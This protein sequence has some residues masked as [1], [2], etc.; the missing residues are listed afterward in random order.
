V[1]GHAVST[2][3]WRDI[4]EWI[5]LLLVLVGMFTLARLAW[6]I[7]TVVTSWVGGTVRSRRR[8]SD[9]QLA[10]ALARIA[11]ILEREAR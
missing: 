7:V 8:I 5:L 2:V 6:R 10:A 1:T 11:E 4:H 3:D 9:E